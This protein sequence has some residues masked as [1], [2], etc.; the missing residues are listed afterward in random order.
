VTS[1]RRERIALLVDEALELPPDRREAFVAARCAD[2]EAMRREVQE[3]LA[4][5]DDMDSNFLE[6]PAALGLD[7]HDAGAEER[8]GPDPMVGRLIGAYRLEA[9]LGRGGMGAVYLARRAD[10]EYERQVA[11]KLLHPG[12]AS[13]GLLRRFRSERQILARL[14]HP[15]IA[16]LLDGGTAEDGQPY[17]VMELITGV[18]IDAYCDEHGLGVRERLLLFR[19]VCEAV[20]FAHQNLVVHRDLK[21]SNILITAQG[22]P[23]LLDFGIAKLVEAP[24]GPQSAEVT[25]SLLHAMTPSYASPEQLAGRN[26]TTVSDVYSLGVILYKLLTGRLP[27]RI[28]LRSP[29]ALEAELAREPERPST[30]ASREDDEVSGST[31]SRPHL[32]PRQLRRQLSGDLDTI[33]LMA[34]R[35]EPERRYGSVEQLA[36]DVR[37]HLEGLPVRARRGT[38]TYRAGKF[39]RRNR[40][41]VSAAAAIFAL[42][43]GLAATATLQAQ[44]IA[45]EREAAEQQRAR[46]ERERDKAQRVADFM[47]ELF[48]KAGNTQDTTARELLDR[49]AAGLHGELQGDDP[50]VRATLLFA[51]GKVYAQMG[52]SIEAKRHLGEALRSREKLFGPD[53][54]DVAEVVT[55]LAEAEQYEGELDEAE[56]H[57]RRAL[58][59]RERKLGQSDPLVAESLVMLGSIYGDMQRLQEAEE[60][61]ARGLRILESRLGPTASDVAKTL[62]NLG[63]IYRQQRKQAQAEAAFRRALAIEENRYGPDHPALATIL[64]NLALALHDDGRLEEAARLYRRSIALKERS[65]GQ[66]PRLAASLFNLALLEASLG[67]YELAERRLVRAQEICEATI[68]PE[69]LHVGNILAQRAMI[70][71]NRGEVELAEPLLQRGMRMVEASVGPEHRQFA[72]TLIQMA[73]LDVRRGRLRAAVAAD[74]RA[75]RIVRAQLGPAH[76]AV[77]LVS[78][79]LAEALAQQGDTRRAASLLAEVVAATEERLKKRPED[80][81][82]LL[83]LSSA[84]LESGRLAAAAG[85]HET[86]APRFARASELL[87]PFAVESHV[88]EYGRVYAE[89]LVFLGRVDE[90]RPIV[91]RLLAT[92]WRDPRFL[93]VMRDHGLGQQG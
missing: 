76:R 63:L 73:S 70:H 36:D 59:I 89:A 90:A 71:R 39:L 86:A 54:L 9:L 29:Q 14:D 2:D 37:R 53:H 28:D 88:I 23:K 47:A 84:W 8:S 60:L 57:V 74:E 19:E 44:R 58:G 32:D 16:K 68:G 30:A 21:P 81:E 13:A 64:N 92:G 4:A 41:G 87:E 91:D 31:V 18:R 27:R 7:A 52:L 67:E 83:L 62:D 69:N 78:L 48:E 11:V 34:L 66:T 40:L 10:D 3:L 80:R 55:R 43:L 65:D 17:L 93:S 45:R 61:T 20:Q 75:L 33:V 6:R 38:F 82:E 12:F 1:E 77:S 42:A 72:T 56:K 85:D 5:D 49:G 22:T 26:V 50:E 35:T 46:A 25:K 51:V 15:N 79:Q 24:H